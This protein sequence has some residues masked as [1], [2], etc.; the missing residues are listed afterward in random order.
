MENQHDKSASARQY[1]PPLTQVV[2]T[3]IC[4]KLL[5][6][7]GNLITHP[8][9]DCECRRRVSLGQRG[10]FKA[11]MNALDLAGKDGTLFVSVIADGD[12]V[13]ELLP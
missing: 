6:T 4:N 11:P 13:I 2:L 7:S 8:P 12:D 9:K 10:I 3:V 1:Y 5:Q